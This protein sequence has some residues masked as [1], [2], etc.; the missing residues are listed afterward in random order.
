[1]AEIENKVDFKQQIKD[2]RIA[3][4]KSVDKLKKLESTGTENDANEAL[5]VASAIW[6]GK[7]YGEIESA[8]RAKGH[9]SGLQKSMEKLGA[10]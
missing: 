4:E 5:W 3:T 6:N 10:I 2:L 9:K 8:L 7:E 1:M